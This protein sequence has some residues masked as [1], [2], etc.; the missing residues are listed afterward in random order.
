MN[1]HKQVAQQAQDDQQHIAAQDWQP[2][3]QEKRDEMVKRYPPCEGFEEAYYSKDYRVLVYAYPG[4][5]A[6]YSRANK[7]ISSWA[8]LQAIKNHFWGEDA[9]AIEF[10]P[11][12]RLVINGAHTRHLWRADSLADVVERFAN[13]GG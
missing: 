13:R 3:S 9:L 5:L 7:P 4:R 11:P 10:F 8:V 12:Q 1:L 6:I 2:M